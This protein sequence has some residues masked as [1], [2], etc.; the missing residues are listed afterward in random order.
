M[1]WTSDGPNNRIC[2]RSC[3]YSL[4]FSGFA[5]AFAFTLR[6]A[7]ILRNANILVYDEKRSRLSAERA[8][9]LLFLKFNLPKESSTIDHAFSCSSVNQLSSYPL[10][11]GGVW[12]KRVVGCV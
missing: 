3:E 12:G 9:E 7:N 8:E 4:C 10:S 2:I 1:V 11:K 5:L 6:H